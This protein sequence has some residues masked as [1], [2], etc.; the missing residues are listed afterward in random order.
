ML[1]QWESQLAQISPAQTSLSAPVFPHSAPFPTHHLHRASVPESA[2]EALAPAK[3]DPYDLYEKSR[4]IYES[5]RKYLSPNCKRSDKVDS[6]LQG[7]APGPQTNTYVLLSTFPFSSCHIFPSICC[8]TSLKYS[9]D[10]TR[11]SPNIGTPIVPS[12]PTSPYCTH[13]HCSSYRLEYLYIQ[14]WTFCQLV[15]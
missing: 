10:I 8:L 11:C 2:S 12:F 14:T 1:E 3:P 13:T 6:S 9:P 4:A 15:S 5:R 7:G